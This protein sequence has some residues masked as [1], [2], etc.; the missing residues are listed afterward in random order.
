M[1]MRDRTGLKS[2][3]IACRV[4][5]NIQKNKSGHIQ[6]D[7]NPQRNGLTLSFARSRIRVREASMTRLWPRSTASA[8]TLAA[9]RRWMWWI[10]LVPAAAPPIS[11]D[12]PKAEP[13]PTNPC[14]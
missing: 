6:I 5:W 11:W 10:H 13:N 7:S 12:S 2:T 9:L 4:E 14:S 1:E 3:R 8:D